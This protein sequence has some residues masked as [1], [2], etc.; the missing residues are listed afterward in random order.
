MKNHS[1]H[2]DTM[3]TLAKVSALSSQLDELS[4]ASPSFRYAFFGK[5]LVSLLTLN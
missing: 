2:T 4:S 3:G 1:V 5:R